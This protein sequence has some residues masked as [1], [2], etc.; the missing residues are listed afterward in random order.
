MPTL[1]LNMIVKNESRIIQRLLA[2]VEKIIDCFC[3]HDTGST[4]NTVSL[5]KEFSDRTGIPGKIVEKP[6]VNFAVSR[7]AALCDACPMADFILLLDADMQLIVDPRFTKDVLETADVFRVQQGTDAFQYCN[8]RVVRSRVAENYAGVTHEYINVRSGARMAELPLL[9]IN[10]IGDGGSKGDKVA[11]DIRLLTQ[12]IKDEPNN[13]R[14]HFYLANTYM[15]ARQFEMAVSLY[16]KRIDLGGWEEEKYYSMYKQALAYKE[17]GDYDKFVE[18][19]VRAWMFRPSRIESI[20]E[21]VK[22]CREQSKYEAARGFY[23]MVRGTPLSK[24]GLFVHKNVYDYALD[25]EFSLLAFY[26]KDTKMVYPVYK[27]LFESPHVNLYSQFGN[28]KFYVPILQGKS[29][30]L[31]CEHSMTID[32]NEH[33]MRGS[34]PSIVATKDGY[35]VNVRLVNYTISPSGSYDFRHNVVATENKRIRL[36]HELKIVSEK[37]LSS[38]TEARI[39]NG[40]GDKKLRGVEDLKLVIRGDDVVFSGTLAHA[41]GRIG[42]CT[43]KYDDELCPTE[44]EMKASCEKNWVFLPGGKEMVYNWRPLQYGPLLGNE[45]NIQHRKEMPRLFEMARGSCNGVEFENEYWF[46]VHFVHKHGD[47]IRFYYHSIVVFDKQMN[48]IEEFNSLTEASNITGVLHQNI[49]ACCKGKRSRTAGGFIWRYKE[50]TKEE[51]KATKEKEKPRTVIHDSDWISPW[52][53]KKHSK[54]TKE[55]MKKNWENIK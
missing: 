19:S 39:P 23:F 25:Y 48:L 29:I 16:Q 10:D 21:V 18:V 1:C 36:D 34:S 33:V 12:G 11:R 46:V 15:D 49:N 30:N 38:K 14:Y 4:D 54:E 20:Y 27:S 2:S 13:G 52:I 28:Y 35:L 26:A 50:Q 3:I 32:G 5:I 24:D 53:G 55:L 51:I 6:F 43:G 41:D 8:T 9:R 40:W 37:I 45:L 31:A 7:T 47:E 22:L 44:L 42:M 17:L